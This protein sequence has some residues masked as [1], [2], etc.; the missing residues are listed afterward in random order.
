[1]IEEELKSLNRRSACE[2]LQR[3]AIPLARSARI[4]ACARGSP[5]ALALSS[6]VAQRSAVP[7]LDPACP[8]LVRTLVEWLLADVDELQ[9]LLAL[10][11]CATFRIINV[12]LLSAMLDGPGNAAFDRLSRQHFILRRA[13]GL[14]V[15]DLVRD[16]VIRQLRARDL[17]QH[18]DLIQRGAD[19]LLE[20]PAT[21]S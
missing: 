19:Y 10:P 18:H 2:H 21:L 15:D 16:V 3:R 7:V 12:P 4:L 11:A 9:Y 8:D 5:L 13:E 6:D 14:V 20:A 1:M 17:A